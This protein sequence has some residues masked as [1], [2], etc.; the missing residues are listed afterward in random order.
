MSHHLVAAACLNQTPLAWERNL[1]HVLGA[2]RAARDAGASVLCLP[3]LCLSGHGCQDAWLLPATWRQAE[4]SLAVVAAAAQGLVVAVGLPVRHDGALYDAAALLVDGRL[5]G[6]V[7]KHELAMGGAVSEA[8]WFRAWPRGARGEVR[9]LG[10]DVPLGDVVCA[11]G[12]LGVGLVLGE[13]LELPSAAPEAP[14]ARLLLNPCALPFS[15]GRYALRYQRL[16]ARS[17]QLGVAVASANLLGNEAGTLLYDGAALV[18]E[19]GALLGATERFGYR[20]WALAYGAVPREAA[21]TSA[22]VERSGAPS[23]APREVGAPPRDE[24]PTSPTPPAWEGAEALEEELTRALALGLFDYLR[25][26][27]ARAFV[28]SLSGG[29]DSAMVASLAALSVRFAVEQLGLARV[30]ER[31]GHPGL[32]LRATTVEGLLAT[33]LHTV[34][35]PTDNSSAVTRQAASELAAALGATHRE[36]PLQPL[37]TQYVELASAALGRA[38]EWDTDDL[39][40]QNV[41]ARARS[42]GAWLLANALAGLLLNTGNRSEAAVGYATLDGDT[43]GVLAPI[44]GLDKVT[45][46]RWLHWLETKGPAGLGALPALAKVN[47]Q[48]PT[49]ELRPPRFHQTDEADLMP[50]PALNVMERVLVEEQGGP[51]EAY[52]ALEAWRASDAV[53]ARYLWVERFFQRWAQSQWKRER[54]P[55]AFYVGEP[56]VDAKSG[57]RFPILSG[58]FEQELARLRAELRL[59]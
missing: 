1:E 36:L 41:Q 56:S 34:Y 42:P 35:Q 21:P 48:A 53:D 40:L 31:L 5:V 37:V 29:A 10:G 55:P 49:A 50:Y 6:V 11:W 14:P 43:S 16:L 18:M 7:P 4:E 12:E 59:P 51:R 30:V 52:R 27:G 57:F 33:L 9:L 58:G 44:G 15:P 13:A 17:A 28:V 8:R 26:V 3:E 39:A 19:R 2:L 38:L 23:R 22:H 20:D 32:D 45:V 46:R 24:P 54:E 47:R 25:K